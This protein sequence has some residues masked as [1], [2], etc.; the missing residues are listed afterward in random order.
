[1]PGKTGTGGCVAL[2]EP[3]LEAVQDFAQDGAVLAIMPRQAL[4]RFK[5][6]LPPN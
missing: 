6:C 3:Q 4:E 5:G 1:L 2:P